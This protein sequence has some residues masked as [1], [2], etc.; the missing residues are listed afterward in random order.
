MHGGILCRNVKVRIFSLKNFR[1]VKIIIKDGGYTPLL[2]PMPLH[3][4]MT[5]I[6]NLAHGSL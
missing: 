1:L 5:C 3:N 6:H 2:H 4:R